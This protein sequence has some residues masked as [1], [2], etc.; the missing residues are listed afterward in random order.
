MIE[1]T[2][3]ELGLLVTWIIIVILGFLLVTAILIQY[4]G[5]IGTLSLY[6]IISASIYGL[7]NYGVVTIL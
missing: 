1:L 2:L 3:M 5:R 4:L 7:I 6:A